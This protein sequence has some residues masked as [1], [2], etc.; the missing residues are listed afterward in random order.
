MFSSFVLF[1]KKLFCVINYWFNVL[2]FVF[3]V[4]VVMYLL[5]I[6][7]INKIS[8]LIDYWLLFI[9]IDVVI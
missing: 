5:F 1:F 4:I 8:I 9:I 7:I 6:I 3:V 2:E